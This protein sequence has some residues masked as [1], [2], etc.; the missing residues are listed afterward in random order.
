MVLAW[1]VGWESGTKSYLK[2]DNVLTTY[3]LLLPI[4]RSA[5]PTPSR[6]ALRRCAP[7]VRAAENCHLLI[8]LPA[9]EA[10]ESPIPRRTMSRLGASEVVTPSIASA[11]SS[12]RRVF[13]A[14]RNCGGRLRNR[15]AAAVRATGRRETSSP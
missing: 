2:E 9:S 1:C 3:L 10:G 13:V 5:P 6:D 15:A 4:R 14:S 8:S 12:A 7:S 11:T